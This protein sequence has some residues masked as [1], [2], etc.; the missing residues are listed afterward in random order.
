MSILNC[1]FSSCFLNALKARNIY[2]WVFH[3]N[4]H[5]LSAFSILACHIFAEVFLQFHWFLLCDHDEILD[6]PQAMSWRP[7]LLSPKLT[8]SLMRPQMPT[9]AGLFQVTFLLLVMV[10]LEIHMEHWVLDM[11]LP[12]MGRW[13]FYFIFSICNWQ[14]ALYFPLLSMPFCSL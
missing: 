1:T 14:L 3:S 11:V 5:S 10:S 4:D 12:D 7:L 9:K 13:S 2:K 6:E 8:G